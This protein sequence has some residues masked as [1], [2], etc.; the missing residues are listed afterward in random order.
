MYCT[1]ADVRNLY[2]SLK[3]LTKINSIL[4]I[5][6]LKWDPINSC[7]I[8]LFKIL[9]SKILVNPPHIE[10]IS[11]YFYLNTMKKQSNNA[12]NSFLGNTYKI[13]L[14]TFNNEV[15]NNNNNFNYNNNIALTQEKR[16]DVSK[17]NKHK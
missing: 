16:K 13:P 15:Q 2:N 6:A 8:Y 9:L 11:N 7:K 4:N 5:L 12:C 3:N 1:I 10:N 14:Q 17:N